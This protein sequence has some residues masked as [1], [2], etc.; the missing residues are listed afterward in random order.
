MLSLRLL[1]ALS[2]GVRV[3]D[4]AALNKHPINVYSMPLRQKYNPS[5]QVSPAAKDAMAVFCGSGQR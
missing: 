3:R 2:P 4:Y 1:R 5:L